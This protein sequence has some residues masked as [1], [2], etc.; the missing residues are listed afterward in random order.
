MKRSIA[1]TLRKIVRIA[2]LAG[3]AAFMGA[4]AAQPI[5]VGFRATAVTGPAAGTTS[6]GTFTYDASIVPAGGGLVAATGL[7][8]DFMFTFNG[9]PFDETTANTGS[10]TFDPA[11]NVLFAL[12]G[13]NCGV[14]VCDIRP[15]TNDFLVFAGAAFGMPRTTPGTADVFAGTALLSSKQRASR[16]RDPHAVAR[17]A[18]SRRLRRPQ[19][20]PARIAERS[21]PIGGLMTGDTKGRAS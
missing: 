11:G 19:E 4:A 16:A 17:R 6:T 13:T 18:R 8:T 9:T 15:G 14:G 20:A 12:F 21:S 1:M 5:S 10:L 3:F 2:V 7:F